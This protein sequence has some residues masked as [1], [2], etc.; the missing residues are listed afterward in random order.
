MFGNKGNFD[1]LSRI[2]LF[3]RV[4]VG[5]G[6][7]IVIRIFY[8]DV[9]RLDNVTNVAICHLWSGSSVDMD[10]QHDEFFEL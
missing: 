9:E 6:A 7:V 5:E 8:R 1:E 2:V 3:L 10:V 4:V